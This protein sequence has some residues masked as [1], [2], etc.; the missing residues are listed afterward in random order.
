M[1]GILSASDNLSPHQFKFYHGTAGWNLQPGDRL[2]PEKANRDRNHD[3][4]EPDKVYFTSDP[5]MAKKYAYGHKD[6]VPAEGSWPEVHE[7]RPTGVWSADK[8]NS[9]AVYPQ[10]RSFETKHALEVVRR[11]L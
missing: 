10:A 6:A 1:A 8:N 7:V 5:E 4:S 9:S 2:T 11:V 3:I